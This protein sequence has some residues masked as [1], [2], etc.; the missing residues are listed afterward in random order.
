M[1]KDGPGRGPADG[2]PANRIAPDGEPPPSIFN[3]LQEQLGLKLEARKG[4]VD[5]LVI[6]HVEKKPAEN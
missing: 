3:A 5:L 1:I 4:P 6:D 2:D